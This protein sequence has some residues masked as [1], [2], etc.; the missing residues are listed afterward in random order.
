MQKPNSPIR[1]IV[2]WQN[3]LAMFFPNILHSSVPLHYTFNIKNTTQ[4]MYDGQEI[5]AI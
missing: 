3:R 1:P 5:I 4:L 2:N